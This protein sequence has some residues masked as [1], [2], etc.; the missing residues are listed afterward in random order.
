MKVLSSSRNELVRQFGMFL[1]TGA[2]NGKTVGNL[3]QAYY[4][5][6]ITPVNQPLRY[7]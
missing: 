7:D 4:F 2:R 3:V 1:V 6:W 5:W